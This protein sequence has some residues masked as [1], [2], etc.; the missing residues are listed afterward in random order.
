[1]SELKNKK[2]LLVDD[3]LDLLEQH[4]LLFQSKGYE[5]VTADNSK[6]GFEI[7]KKEKPDAAVIDLIMEQHDSGFILCYKIKKDEHGKKLFLFLCLL[8]LLMIPGIN[9]ARQLMKRKSG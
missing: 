3:D 7:F 9:S 5:V 8:Q 4:K 6:E 1:M 2:V